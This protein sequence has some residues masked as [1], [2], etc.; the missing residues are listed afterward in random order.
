MQCRLPVIS[1]NQWIAPMLSNRTIDQSMASLFAILT[2]CVPAV[3]DDPNP[4]RIGHLRSA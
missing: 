3:A 1:G 2:T 4:V